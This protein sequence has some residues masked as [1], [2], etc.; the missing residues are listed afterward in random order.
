[1][2]KK[3]GVQSS[4]RPWVGGVALGCIIIG[5]FLSSFAVNVAK[6]LGLIHNDVYQN[7]F[8]MKHV[9]DTI[10]MGTWVN[11]SNL[12]MLYGF[13]GSYFFNEPFILH[14]IAGLPIYTATG[15][16]V[17]TYNV[18]TVLTLLASFLAVYAFAH[19][20][21]GKIIPSVIAAV[22][23]VLN[24]YIM[25][26]FP[27]HLNLVTLVFLPLIFLCVEW[28]LARPTSWNCFFLFLLLTGQ[29]LTSFYYAAF[30]TLILPLYIGIR[31]WQ[32]KTDVR[33]VLRW[34][35]LVGVVLFFLVIACMVKIYSG[36][37]LFSESSND[38]DRQQLL[39]FSAW[40]TD[41]LFM[42]EHNMLYGAIRPWVTKNFP[43]IVHMG[44]PAEQSLFPGITVVI[45]WIFS[46]FI[47]RKTSYKHYFSVFAII[48]GL[49]FILSLGPV[50][51][52]TST[53]TVP[54]VF[55]IVAALNPALRMTRVAARFSVFV[56]LFGGLIAG[57]TIDT[58]TKG[59]RSLVVIILVCI[60]VE[61]WC[62]PFD[63][64]TVRPATMALYSR[65]NEQKNIRVILDVPVG[66]AMLKNGGSVRQEY[67]DARYMLWATIAHDKTLIGGYEGFMPLGHYVR[68]HEISTS[69]PS[70]ETV[71]LIRLWGAD[72]VILHRDEY[73]HP[74]D[75][76]LAKV[77]LTSMGVP[78]VEESDG[79]ALFD[80]TMWK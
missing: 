47:L 42:P 38:L 40:P 27:D 70:P 43:D 39:Y 33:K 56:F 71:S 58:I 53:V 13:S 62:R 80:L 31:W 51:H 3:Q 10:R 12:P 23:G 48:S 78:L 32:V 74:T 52:V 30:L 57:M 29:A 65:L 45:V 75:Y 61:Y 8:I 19:H 9:M 20:V 28:I 49:C 36:T 22:V 54:G 11:L 21:T 63:F 50:I 67:L 64:L 76:H 69:F 44:T 16:I 66:D 14:A 5:V 34:G 2:H 17:V 59:K 15:N 79:L 25:A 18:L 26:R 46:F 77:K 41:W 60:L 37:F 6:P 7:M 24:P 1:M 73:M 72:A 35:S 68:M 4:A 55:D